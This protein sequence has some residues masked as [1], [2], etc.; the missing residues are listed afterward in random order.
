[1]SENEHVMR[2]DIVLLKRQPTQTFLNLIN[3][4]IILVVD[5][6]SCC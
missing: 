2:Q 5:R 3:K 1:M 4:S 6:R